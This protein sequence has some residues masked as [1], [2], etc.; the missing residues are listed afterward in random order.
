MGNS[1]LMLNYPWGFRKVRVC[2]ETLRES[3]AYIL[4]DVRLSELQMA[5][6]HL[7]R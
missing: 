3:F 7:L 5:K 2:A 6:K 4:L 1:N